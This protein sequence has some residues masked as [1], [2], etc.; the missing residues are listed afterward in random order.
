MPKRLGAAQVP[1]LTARALRQRDASIPPVSTE[2]IDQAQDDR[3]SLKFP[4]AA[5]PKQ[6]LDSVR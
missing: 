6:A 1:P 2:V 5:A 4:S 3:D